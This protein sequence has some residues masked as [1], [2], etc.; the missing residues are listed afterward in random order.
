MNVYVATCEYLNQREMETIGVFVDQKQAILETTEHVC[1]T[2]FIKTKD[3]RDKIYADLENT[4]TYIQYDGEQ[5]MGERWT[6]K[7]HTMK[8]SAKHTLIISR[9]YNE[10]IPDNN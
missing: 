10:Y 3:L 1:H 6:I 4:N 9:H 8:E 7:E 5:E 2:F